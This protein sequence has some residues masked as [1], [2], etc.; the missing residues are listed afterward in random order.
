MH[1]LL[2]YVA[3]VGKHWNEISQKYYN[4]QLS[5]DTLRMQHKRSEQ[6]INNITNIAQQI[7]DDKPVAQLTKNVLYRMAVDAQ[8]RLDLNEF[9]KL[10]LVDPAALPPAVP[11]ICN[12]PQILNVIHS[13]KRNYLFENWL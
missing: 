4:G 1:Q 5:P 10:Q 6:T 3:M 11:A 9:S 13:A 8:Y 7:I 12:F 2:W